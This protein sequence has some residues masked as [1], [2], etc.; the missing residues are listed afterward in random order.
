MISRKKGTRGLSEHILVW[1]L[2]TIPDIDGFAR[3]NGLS[4]KP[5][6]EIRGQMGDDFPKLVYHRIVCI[7]AL[8]ASSTSEG[9]VVRA[10]DTSHAG[11]LTEPQMIQTFLNVVDRLSPR[12]VTFNGQSFDLPVLRYRAMIHG[13]SAPGLYSRSYFHRYRDDHVDLCDALASFN[14]GGKA[15]LDEICRIMGLDGKPQGIDGSQVER[16]FLEGRVEE[17][18]DYCTSD[19]IDTYRLWLRYELFKGELSTIG[20]TLSDSQIDSF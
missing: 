17:I 3:V 18:A 14:N 11:E 7:G 8:L 4:E 2:E 15:K 13:L 19:V 20:L 5:D 16:L 10:V 9:Y 6:T 12:M 1:D